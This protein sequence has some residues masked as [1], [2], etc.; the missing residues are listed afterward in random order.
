MLAK[1]VISAFVMGP[2]IL[3]FVYL[4]GLPYWALVTVVAI[5]AGYE[6][7]RLISQAGERADYPLTV[8]LILLIM[9]GALYPSWALMRGGMTLLLAFSLLWQMARKGGHLPV[10]SWALSLGGAIYVG[11]LLSHFVSL[12]ALPRGLEWTLLAFFPAWANDTGAYFVGRWIGEHPFAPRISPKKTWEGS[13]GGW[14]LGVAVGT[15]MGAVL[16]LPLLHASLLGLLI[17]LAATGGDLVESMF[18]RWAGVK[19]SGRLIPGHGGVLDRIDSLLF[20]VAAVYYYLIWV[21]KV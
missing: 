11:F 3:G 1:R 7:L 12:R 6:Y 10:V 21:I 14:I 17:S 16:G 8:L 15:L 19:D 13:I 4:G 18:K 9:V 20:S 5:G 2:L